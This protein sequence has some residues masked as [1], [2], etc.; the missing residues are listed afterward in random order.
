MSIQGYFRGGGI[1]KGIESFEVYCPGSALRHW[2]TGRS[3]R[4]PCHAAALAQ[5]SALARLVRAA[6]R[7]GAIPRHQKGR[8]T[9]HARPRQLLEVVR[10]APKAQRA[11]PGGHLLD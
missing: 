6:G 8:M 4:S 11:V 1:T 9:D 7:E 3:Q 2:Q 5:A 10:V